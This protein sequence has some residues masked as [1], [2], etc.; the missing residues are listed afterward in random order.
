M[1]SK[2]APDDA[3]PRPPWR[4]AT[5]WSLSARLAAAF[6]VAASSLLLI[7]T[8]LLYWALAGNLDREDNEYLGAKVAALETVLREHPRDAAALGA[9]V[10]RESHQQFYPPIFVRIDD[11]H[12]HNL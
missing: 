11:G 2:T 4:A 8:A 1:S 12:G 3:P 9:E 6:A 10:E 7:T 5:P